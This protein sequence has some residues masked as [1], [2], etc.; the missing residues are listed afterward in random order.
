MSTQHHSAKNGQKQL[1]P[2]IKNVRIVKKNIKKIRILREIKR[3]YESSFL[4]KINLTKIK[5]D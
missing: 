5:Y 2:N 3:R 1:K 4:K